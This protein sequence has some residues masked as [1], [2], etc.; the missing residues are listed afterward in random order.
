MTNGKR[1]AWP[2][3]HFHEVITSGV[4][5]KCSESAR[6]ADAE[7][8]PWCNPFPEHA[9]QPCHDKREH[10][11]VTSAAANNVGEQ[12]QERGG[13][14]CTSA[15]L[16]SLSRLLL[17]AERRRHHLAG[18]F[19]DL[20]Q[21]LLAPEALAVDFV[22]VLGAAGPGGEPS[23]L[24]GDLEAADGRVV[25]GC[26]GQL[27]GDGVTRQRGRRDLFGREVRQDLF[28]LGVGGR[29]HP[30]VRRFAVAGGQVAQALGGRLARPGRHLGGEQTGNQTVLVGAPGAAVEPQETRARRLLTAEAEFTREQTLHE[31]FEAHRHLDE[32]PPQAR[33]H[34][35]NEGRTHQRFADPSTG[36]PAGAILEQV[37]DHD[38]EVV[39][40]VHQAVFGH[41]A[42]AVGV[43][44]VA[45]GDVEIVLEAQQARHRVGAG[46]VHANLAVLVHR[47]EGEAR[48]DLA[49][50]DGQAEAIARL[51][52]LPHRQA[53]PTE[54]IDADAHARLPNHIQV[55]DLRQLLDVG[56]D[57]VEGQG[58]SQRV[59][60][61]NLFYIFQ[62]AAHRSLARACTCPVT[63]V[64]AGPPEGGLYLKPPS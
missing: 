49:V 7:K 6:V 47:H 37:F 38:G 9:F 33:C 25:A 39:V 35:V 2:R 58:R 42:V 52:R 45:D 5:R 63:S 56:R 50:D 43:G 4:K 21:V 44:V 20:L 8:R 10:R 13:E 17:T 60:E 34:P 59:G 36:L 19:E 31:V 15:A 55:D 48:V 32:P 53:G 40:G 30:A 22:H 61:G 12:E 24:G 54:R 27:G 29:V 16:S 23:V 28:L 14:A 46:A 18:F 64:S 51:N 62:A 26:A 11:R 41:D 1:R 57:E 3:C